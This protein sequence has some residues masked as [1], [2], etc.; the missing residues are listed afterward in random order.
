VREKRGSTTGLQ[1]GDRKL[2]LDEDES[3]KGLEAPQ[4][5]RRYLAPYTARGDE[6]LTDGPRQNCCGR[7]SVRTAS[8]DGSDP[9]D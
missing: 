9:S 3:I 8:K 5:R 4:A 6:A 7:D 2:E 1:R